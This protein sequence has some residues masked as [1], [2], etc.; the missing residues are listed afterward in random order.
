MDHFAK[1]PYFHRVQHTDVHAAK[2][3][4][5]LEINKLKLR[6]EALEKQLKELMEESNG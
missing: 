3:E 2:S 5:M 4:V 1:D 6:I